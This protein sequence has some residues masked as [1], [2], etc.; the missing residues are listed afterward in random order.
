MAFLG[1]MMELMTDARHNPAKLPVAL[2]SFGIIL[3]AAA[4]SLV[5]FMAPAGG[6]FIRLHGSAPVFTY[7]GI[8][9]AVV[10]FGLAV[11]SFGFWVVPRD[12]QGWHA[13][14]KTV[15]WICLLPLVLVAALGGLVFLK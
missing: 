13:A 7:Y 1:R 4:L 2:M 5:I 14:G 11:A 10:I 9:I 15:L 6:I 3:S 8:L 12:P